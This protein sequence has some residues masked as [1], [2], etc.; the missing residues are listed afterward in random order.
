MTIFKDVPNLRRIVWKRVEH[1]A[2]DQFFWLFQ[3]VVETPLI[4]ILCIFKD[5]QAFQSSYPLI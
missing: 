3:R 5:I 1:T 2:L 4:G